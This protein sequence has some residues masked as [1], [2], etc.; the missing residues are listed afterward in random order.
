MVKKNFDAKAR[1]ALKI[2]KAKSWWTFTELMGEVSSY[3]EMKDFYS[4]CKS[5]G[6]R[7]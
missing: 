5:R 4:Y 6:F 7:V 2:S 3:K 1:L